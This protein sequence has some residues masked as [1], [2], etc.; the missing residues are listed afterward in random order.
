MTSK[1]ALERLETKISNA[2]VTPVSIWHIAKSLLKR[3][4]LRAPTAIHG[5]SGLKFHPFDKANAIADCLEIQFTPHDLYDENNEWQVEAKVQ[6]LMESV[7]NSIPQ[8]IRPCD[9]QKLI[10]TLKLTK[11]CGIDG[12]PNE[13]L[14]HLPRRPQVH[15]TH[16]FNHCLRL[17]H[18]TY[19]WKEARVIALPKPGKD[20]KFPQ[21]LRP[22]G[23]LSTTGKLFEK[24]IQKVL[25]KHIEERGLLNASQFG[26]RARHSTTLQCMRL[27]DHVTLNFNKKLSTAT[28][29][30]DIEKAF[31]TTWHCDLLYRLSKLEF[32]TSL[33]KLI[34]FFLSQRQFTVSVEGGTSTPRVM[35]AEGATRFGPLPYSFQHVYK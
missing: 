32:S 34:G 8:R 3:D 10:N 9:I 1:R 26:F 23:F 27:T 28:V 25:Q 31:D 24:L 7:D 29:F 15:L 4:G 35:Q 20:L 13:C 21:N 30:L 2:E 11:A 19:P 6:A 17:S 33:I 14:R 18:F 22:I 5:A 12:I 16:L